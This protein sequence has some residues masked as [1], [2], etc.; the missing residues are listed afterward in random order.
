MP[1]ISRPDREGRRLMDAEFKRAEWQR[2]HEARTGIKRQFKIARQSSLVREETPHEREERERQRELKR[3]REQ[4]RVQLEYEHYP[5]LASDGLAE[6]MRDFVY[7]P[8]LGNTPDNVISDQRVRDLVPLLEAHTVDPLWMEP[9]R[10]DEAQLLIW[11]KYWRGVKSGK[12]QRP[13]PK[14]HRPITLPTL[15]GQSP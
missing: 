4:R 11:W 14:S 12:I 5:F 1:K 15:R 10:M 9:V 2:V 8:L 3:A 6:R 13:L 7:E